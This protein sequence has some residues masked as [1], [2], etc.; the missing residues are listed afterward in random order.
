VRAT[1]FHGRLRSER[2]AR[3]LAVRAQREALRRL[4]ALL[5]HDLR[6]QQT[7]GAHLRDLDHR[8]HA[9]RP[10][11]RDARREVVD[12]ETGVAAAA[13]VLEAVGERVGEFD[14]GGRA[15]FLHVVARHRD[16]VELR[17]VLR[18]PREDVADH[19]HRRLR[20]ED[21]GVADHELLEHVV[22]DRARESVRGDTLLLRRDDV[23]REDRDHRAVH[24]H[25]D[26]DLI[27][28]D[29]IEQDPHVEDR[30]DRDSRHADVA[31]D[32]RMVAVV[33]AVRREVERDAEA[34]LAAG[35]VAAVERVGRLGGREPRVLPHRPRPGRV[36][37]GVRAA[38]VGREAGQEAQC[39]SDPRSSRDRNGLG[40][41]GP[42][43]GSARR[44]PRARSRRAAPRS[45]T[46]GPRWHPA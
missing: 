38:Q 28:R 37:R 12:L 10:E 26:A 1:L 14:L 24:R 29:A 34:L 46:R 19:A 22:L 44:G 40:S 27:E 41:R 21:V 42:R 15:G 25:R 20:R 36:H 18:A 8:V 11:E 9:D 7:A 39:A 16:A 31:L 6:P 3:R 17:H 13:Q 30:I 32:A 5:A 35:E 43:A 23:Q 33:A 2:P 4:A 45:R